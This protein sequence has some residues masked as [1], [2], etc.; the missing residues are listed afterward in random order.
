MNRVYLA[1]PI[2][3]LTWS[4]SSIWRDQA[5]TA[6]AKDG[7]ECFSPMRDCDNLTQVGVIDGTCSYDDGL[8]TTSRAV[9]SRDFFDVKRADLILVNLHS[10]KK[11]SIGTI[12]EIAWA[13]QMQKPV[14]II[15]EPTN[16]QVAHIMVQEAASVIVPDLNQAISVVRSY[17][18]NHIGPQL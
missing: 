13:W 4:E 1:G 6:L 8:L 9:M 10:A 11:V 7:V 14:V 16:Q 5:A 15:A 2:S 17:C 3:G 12:M 18:R